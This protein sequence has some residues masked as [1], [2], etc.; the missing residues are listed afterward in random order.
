[1]SEPYFQDN[2]VTLYRGDC[3]SAARFFYCPKADKEDRSSDVGA[4]NTHPT[5]K[6]TDL[7]RYLIRLV[8]REGGLILD[9]FLG[10]G[11]TAYAA[12]EE[13]VNCIGIEREEEY[14][15]IAVSRL[16]QKVLF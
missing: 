1:M 4:K 10:S 6:P 13:G 3:I 8:V 5:V 16:K 7:M 15:R 12:R 11:T 2:R 9:P 14:L